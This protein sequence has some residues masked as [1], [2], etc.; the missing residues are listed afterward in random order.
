MA[1]PQ[2]PEIPQEQEIGA[3]TV[4]SSVDLLKAVAK[5]GRNGGGLS[6]AMETLGEA[7]TTR[8]KAY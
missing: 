7:T 8:E 4:S 2:A 6:A 3:R 1:F 5:Q